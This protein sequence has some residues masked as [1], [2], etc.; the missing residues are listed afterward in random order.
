VKRSIYRANELG[1]V[2]Y[3][4]RILDL[5]GDYESYQSIVYNKAAF[6]ILMLKDMIG[7][8]E[9]CNRIRRLLKIFQH[10]S[11][12]SMDFIRQFSQDNP[13]IF[14]FLG[15]WINHRR[16][17]R[18]S[19]FIEKGGRSARITVEQTGEAIP[20]PLILAITTGQ[21]EHTRTLLVSQKR[22]RFDIREESVIKTI[23]IDSSRNL[24]RL[25]RQQ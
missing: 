3:G 16:I 11:V 24:V 4:R 7:E 1:P 10:K 8:Q 19:V 22:Q 17:P 12:N 23:G 14:N 13:V 5:H 21:G 2:V 25:N 9:F 15:H 18:A 20:F 6:I